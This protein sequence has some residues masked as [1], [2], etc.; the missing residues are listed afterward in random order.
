ML[1]S[2]K[3]TRKLHERR[4]LFAVPQNHQDDFAGLL[5][6]YRRKGI[7]VD[8]VPY[9]EDMP[10]AR[11][12]AFRSKGLD[13][14]LLAGSARLAPRTVLPGPFVEDATGR[15]FPAAWLPIKTAASNRRF[16][17]AAARVHQR[18]RQKFTVALLSQWHPKYLRMS[19]RL[20]ALLQKPIETFRWTGDVITR[21]G[22]VDALSAGLGLALYVGH[23]RP[24]GWV[25]YFGMR[26]HHFED[27]DGEPVGAMLSLCCRTASRW[28][29]GLSYSETL[30]L[31]GV[32]A[33]SFGAVT[34]TRHTDNTRWASRICES[35]ATGPET[36]GELIVRAAPPLASARSPYRLIGDP[37][38]PLMAETSGAKRAAAVK[39]YP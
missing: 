3:A 23:G 6:A 37:L 20:Q 12:L 5:D 10:D 18:A 16:A 30:P 27:F 21:E 11:D 34:Q 22:L 31:M 8:L 25:G 36:L 19:D 28:R 15:Q 4:L 13:A 17:H 26:G 2:H 24:L 29:T 38:A 35:L 7:H 1:T 14:I 33:S 32:A 9:G 39:T